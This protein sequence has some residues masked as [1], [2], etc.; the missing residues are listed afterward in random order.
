MLYIVSQTPIKQVHTKG[1]LYFTRCFTLQ[2]VCAPDTINCTR[3]FFIGLTVLPCISEE[4]LHLISLIHC[5]FIISPELNFPSMLYITNIYMSICYM[6]YMYICYICAIGMLYI[7][8]IVP[9]IHWPCPFKTARFTL[10][11]LSTYT[12]AACFFFYIGISFL[13]PE[14]RKVATMQFIL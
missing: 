1:Q 8:I 2:D 4:Q 11:H 14:P 7:Y 12:T 6:L 3:C 5:I 9:Y 10:F 13:D